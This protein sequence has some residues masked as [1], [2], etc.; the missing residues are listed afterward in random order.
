MWGKKFGV[1]STYQSLSNE[2]STEQCEALSMTLNYKGHSDLGGRELAQ[3]CRMG[4][5]TQGAIQVRTT[6]AFSSSAG[7]GLDIE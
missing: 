2:E 6:T 1:L 4:W 5:F 3:S 7:N